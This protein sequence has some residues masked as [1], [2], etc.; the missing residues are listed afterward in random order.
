MKEIV[1][2]LKGSE[3]MRGWAGRL[4]IAVKVSSS[5]PSPCTSKGKSW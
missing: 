4:G 2:K 1:G 5:P 3:G